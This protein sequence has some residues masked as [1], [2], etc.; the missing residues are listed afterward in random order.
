MEHKSAESKS[1]VSTRT[2]L[3]TDCTSVEFLLEHPG[4]KDFKSSAK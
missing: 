1:H 2:E 3:H 4:E